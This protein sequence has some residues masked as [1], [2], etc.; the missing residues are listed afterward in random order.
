MVLIGFMG[1]LFTHLALARLSFKP[2]FLGRAVAL[3]IGSL[4]AVGAFRLF[5]GE[6]IDV[7]WRA[8]SD[9]PS[10]V[11]AVGSWLSGDVVVRARPDAV[12][13][14]RA[15]T[16][17]VAWQWSPPGRDTVC[18]MSEVVADGVG[19]LGHGAADKPCGT[20]VALDLATGRPRWSIDADAPVRYGETVHSGVL[21]IAGKT[22]VVQE[23][24]GWRG[25]SMADGR[26]MWRTAAG[27]DC[28][29]VH[30]AGGPST[31]VTVTKCED[32][33]PVLRTLRPADGWQ[34]MRA[35]LPVTTHL[36]NVAVLSTDPVTLWVDEAGS[37]GT[38]AVLGYD[39]SG[40]VRS[41]IPLAQAEYDLQ[42]PAHGYESADF[43]V[44]PAY[45][46]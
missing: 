5:G 38:H 9:R 6:G 7:V 42:I 8:P 26:T 3:V 25:L 28:A 34:G 17:E 15:A 22:A 43:A 11:R 45:A 29:P 37:R 40:R 16:G 4:L 21:A 24:D 35:D 19:L 46:P 39:P 10:D 41:T 23:P 33:P 14:Y 20:V 13:G 18:G 2:S 44:R 27:K 31:V 1:W 36:K 30:L 12:V 32:H